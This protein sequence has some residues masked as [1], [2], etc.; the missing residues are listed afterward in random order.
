M[1]LK[2]ASVHIFSLVRLSQKSSLNASNQLNDSNL[3]NNQFIRYRKTIQPN[4]KKSKHF[5]QIE[6]NDR[7]YIYRIVL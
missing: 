3:P 7:I 6:R 1:T 4:K 2:P 5:C